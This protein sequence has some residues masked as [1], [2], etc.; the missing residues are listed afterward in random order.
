[1][2]WDAIVIG[3]GF[4]GAMAAWPLV[5][6]G[7]RVL[8]LERGGWVGRGPDNWSDRGAGLITPSY[9]HETP[10]DVAA[11]SKNYVAGSW[12]CVGGQ[13]VYY[14][15]ASFRFREHDFDEN[16]RIVG[17]SGA[18]W[19]FRYDVIEPFYGLAERLLGV[20]GETGLHDPPRSLPF[21]QRAAPLSQSSALIAEAGTRVGLTPSRIPLAISFDGAD[22]VRACTRC[23][24]CDGYACAAEAK[25]DLATGII[26]RLVAQGMTL[27]T[28]TVC[29]RLVRQGH[30]ISG[31]E[32]VDRIDGERR[33]FEADTVILAAGALA[34]PHLILASN[35]AR[36][37]PAG[38]CVGRYLTRHRNA[39]VLGLFP[40]Q[41]N[42]RRE[43]DKQVV[44]LDHYAEAGSIQQ[45]TPALGLVKSYLP[46][47]LRHAGAR[48]VAHASGLLVIAED[49]PRHENGVGI[50]WSRRDQ[51]GL[52]RLS[53]QHSY[54]DVDEA[55]ARVLIAAARR[56]LREAGARL[57]MSHAIETFSHA[58]GTVRMG[59]DE[60][61]SPLDGEGRYR[62]M[63]NLY[64]TDGSALPRSA[65][66][67][68]SLTIAANALRIGSLL[69]S[70]TPVLRGRTLRTLAIAPTPALTLTPISIR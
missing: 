46:V 56:V 35:L 53:V 69:G 66:L 3:S 63:E 60:Q 62:G 7:Q 52:Q 54:S 27:R 16:D 70:R 51:F 58:L 19:P 28:N 22:A 23:G 20:S 6:A 10:Y 48:F 29:V 8:M 12:N 4:G 11:G 21:P 36:V 57:F 68:P 32:C 65:G 17:A 45:L 25:N 24:T 14:G 47:G 34:T 37:N 30:R 26:P 67:N 49:Q 31:V 42:P 2:K 59:V 39:V 18:A 41:P 43:F 61:T 50:D 44:F 1:M 5:Q 15:G 33:V 13:S 55:A 38:H 40:R 64:V 9:N